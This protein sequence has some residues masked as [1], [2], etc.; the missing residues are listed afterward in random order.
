MIFFA[1]L[2]F[3]TTANVHRIGLHSLNGLHNIFRG[4]PSRENTGFAGTLYKVPAQIPIKALPR[5]AMLRTGFVQQKGADRIS[6]GR[7]LARQGKTQ[8]LDQTKT[9]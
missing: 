3:D 6:P 5:P 2:G 7:N 4:Q 1:R 8:G 9:F